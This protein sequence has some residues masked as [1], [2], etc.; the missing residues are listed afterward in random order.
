MGDRRRS[1]G[2]LFRGGGDVALSCILLFA[3]EV[4]ISGMGSEGKLFPSVERGLGRHD[5]GERKLLLRRVGRGGSVGG[6][7]VEGGD[8]FLNE[9]IRVGGSVGDG[10]G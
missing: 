2:I 8:G 3:F 4:A 5:G 7:G 9:G 1:G 6:G 10:G